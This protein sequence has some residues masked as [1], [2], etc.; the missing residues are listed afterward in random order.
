[1]LNKALLREIEKGLPGPLYFLWSEESYFLEDAL[2]KIIESVI[3]AGNADFN[4]DVFYPVSTPQEI[5]NAASTLPFM[6]PRRLVAIKDFQA[7]PASA[8][9]AFLTYFREPAETTCMVIMS[10]KAPAASLD[11]GWKVYSLNIQDKDVPAWLRQAAAQKGLKLTDDAVE[12][13]IEYVGY[14]IGLLM[15]ELEKLA[16]GGG[17]TVSGS[18][19]VSSTSMTRENTTFELVDSL[20]AGR[21]TKA[22]RILKN[23]LSNMSAYELPSVLGTL[24]W[25]YKQFYSLWSGKGK[26]PARMNEKTYRALAKHLPSFTEED[27]FRIFLSLHEADVGLK[28][29]GRPELVLEVLLIRLLQKGSLH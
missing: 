5:M 13:L 6:V 23:L 18:D 10:R 11:P 3:P 20:V 12:H 16:S 14:E 22:F 25:H 17:R 24:N 19:I 15:M 4:Y 1:M 28:T 7:F 26:R 21:N 9:K 29:S 2:L 8:V 27:F